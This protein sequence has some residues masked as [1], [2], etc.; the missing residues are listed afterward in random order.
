MTLKKVM[1]ESQADLCLF[2]HK[3]KSKDVIVSNEKKIFEGMTE[4]VVGMLRELDPE[5]PVGFY[6]GSSPVDAVIATG[7]DNAN[8]YFRTQY[9]GIPAL[10]RGSRQ[11]RS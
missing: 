9:A 1:N 2:G 7:S 6:D 3:V 5:V 11:S 8:R 4:Y 10:L